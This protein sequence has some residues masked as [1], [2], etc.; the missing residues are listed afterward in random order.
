MA[1]RLL[2]QPDLLLEFVIDTGFIGDLTLPP[3]AI[4]ALGLPF[5]YSQAVTLA[6]DSDVE[7]PV[8]QALIIWQGS[9]RSVHVLATGNR[10][11]GRASCR[12]RVCST[13]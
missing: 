5:V 7:I 11:I 12:E 6:N 2:N 10:Q 3:V 8:Y 9:E 1:F 13:V 4:A